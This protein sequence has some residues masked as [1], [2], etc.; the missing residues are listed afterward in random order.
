MTPH[1][2]YYACVTED[3][4]WYTKGSGPV[5][6]YLTKEEAMDAMERSGA[7]KVRKFTLDA[8]G[9]LIKTEDFYPSPKS[10]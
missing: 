2:N 5:M 3:N 9:N 10:E 1:K 8:E 7:P 4:Q 6:A